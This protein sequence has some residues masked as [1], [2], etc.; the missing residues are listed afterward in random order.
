MTNILDVDKVCW[1]AGDKDILRDISFSVKKGA[2]V[3]LIGP[4][5]AG[6]SSLLRCLYRVNKPSSGEVRLFGENIWDISAKHNAKKVAVILQEHSEHLGLRVKDVIALGLTPHKRL[7]EMDSLS[8][9]EKVD[10]A[11]SQVDLQSL[12]HESYAHLSGGEKQRVMVARA[13]VQNPELLLMDEPTNHLDIHYQIDVLKLVQKMGVT[14]FSSFHD[15]NLAAAYCDQI[16]VIH[17]GK[18]AAVG[19]AEDVITENMIS[20]IFKTCAVVDVHP[21]HKSPRV[22]YAYE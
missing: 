17:N 12:K 6:K 19:T 16:V 18:L 7:F 9:K 15:L 2:F 11:I 3:G 14:V 5:G 22:T 10:K 4:N 8:D 20:T 13:I 21:L 1:R